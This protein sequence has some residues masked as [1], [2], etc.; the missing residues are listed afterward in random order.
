MG[1]GKAVKGKRGNTLH[2][3]VGGLAGNAAS[4]HP[5]PQ[6][7]LQLLHALQ[8]A[9]GPH[10]PAQLLR[11]TPGK[12]RRHHGH[13]HELLLK[14]RYAQGT[15]QDGLEVGVGVG[16]R[17]PTQA[18]VEVRV[19]HLAHDG[20]RANDGHLHHQI[21]K[22]PG[23]HAGKG[24]HLRPAFHLENSHRVGAAQ[25]VVHCRVVRRQV[26]VVHLHPL[27]LADEGNRHFQHLHHAQAQK[28]HL[29]DPQ[30]PAVILVPLD[31]HPPGHGS[32]LQR[33]HVVQSSCRQHHAT[34]VLP[35]MAGKPGKP[36][37]QLHE[38]LAPP[39]LRIQ[40]HRPHVLGQLFPGI[41]LKAP[42]RKH[43]RKLF[44]AFGIKPQHLSRFPHRRPRPVTNHHCRHPRP[45]LAVGAVH[46]LDDLFP[47]VT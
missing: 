36:R 40:P 19:H 33:H 5:L 22:A 17:F 13:P 30:I 37:H 35:Q 46:V 28:V 27:V 26:G 38:V 18:A 7:P 20:A 23:L 6:L 47:F 1:F 8:G 3:V 43:G 34:G 10:G 14:Q 12:A 4:G 41:A 45:P 31:H 21:V 42:P 44:Q 2:D 29:D 15:L 24:G 16:H 11:L 39:F 32:R 25:H 9:P